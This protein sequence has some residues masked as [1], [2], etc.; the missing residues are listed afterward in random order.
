M[1]LLKGAIAIN[2]WLLLLLLLLLL[3]CLFLLFLLHWC[4]KPRWWFIR[5]KENT[6][7]QTSMSR[8]R[9]VSS[10]GRVSPAMSCKLKMSL[11]FILLAPPTNLSEGH[12]SDL[13]Q[14]SGDTSGLI[15]ILKVE[16]T[17][18]FFLLPVCISAAGCK[19]RANPSC[20]LEFF[21]RG[22]CHLRWNIN[23][24]IVK[25]RPSPLWSLVS[26]S[27][28]EAKQAQK[29]SGNWEKTIK[30]AGQRSLEKKILR[31]VLL[32]FFPPLAAQSTIATLALCCVC[33]SPDERESSDCLFFSCYFSYKWG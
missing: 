8:F 23:W 28:S 30:T 27:R 2:L 33:V 12:N 6:W 25:K 32:F 17:V 26:C 4:F 22:C 5:L 7:N 24:R 10:H 9:A 16:Q 21:R 31:V 14:V 13:S 1:A 20:C 3:L 29:R 11:S 18:C 19:Q 15:F